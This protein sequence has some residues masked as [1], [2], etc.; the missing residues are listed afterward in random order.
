MSLPS[1]H[2]ILNI[3]FENDAFIANDSGYILIHIRNCIASHL[4]GEYLAS[5]VSV[6]FAECLQVIDY[7]AV[8]IGQTH[9]VT[10]SCL[11]FWAAARWY[12]K[13]AFW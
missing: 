13:R 10:P 2:Q 5:R 11:L 6:V 4:E 3:E 9:L 1:T 8:K 12:L 7:L